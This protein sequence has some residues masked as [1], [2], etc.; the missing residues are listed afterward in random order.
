[1]NNSSVIRIILALCVSPVAPAIVVLTWGLAISDHYAWWTS[2]LFVI[3]GYATMLFVGLPIF[4]FVRRKGWTLNVWQCV[5]VGALSG[6][7]SMLA[8]SA[9]D[10]MFGANPLSEKINW[11]LTFAVTA[12]IAG[13]FAGLIFRLI[14]GNLALSPRTLEGR[15]VHS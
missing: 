8:L 9:I 14:A 2:G 13:S 10:L 12:A 3:P 7:T 15:K 6:L 1:M 5:G 11:A 4:L